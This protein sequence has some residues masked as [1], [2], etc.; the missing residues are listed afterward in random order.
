MPSKV[1]SIQPTQSPTNEPTVEP[2]VQ[3][4]M[5]PTQSPITA[6]P[7]TR[8]Q[9]KKAF[10]T[11]LLVNFDD[12]EAYVNS[13]IANMTLNRWA[14]RVIEVMLN[15][16]TAPET[17][18]QVKIDVR[19]VKRGSVIIDCE[20]GINNLDVLNE[21]FSTINDTVSSGQP[22]NAPGGFSFLAEPIVVLNSTDYPTFEPTL[23]PTPDPTMDE[24]K[25]GNY[26]MLS[27]TLLDDW[28]LS[29]DGTVVID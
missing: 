20:L 15:Y 23:D 17:I 27:T 28:T 25:M 16:D 24:C 18:K 2:T 8:R 7:T 13:T 5:N 21:A 12:V 1:P 6:I 29:T 10:I 22:I 9:W 3:P 26:Q 11:T 14:Q 4:T 19:R